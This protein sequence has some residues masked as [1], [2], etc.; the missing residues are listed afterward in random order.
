LARWDWGV[1]LREGKN[2]EVYF[3]LMSKRLKEIEREKN[4]IFPQVY[5]QFYDKCD[6][7]MP[8][9]LTGTDTINKNPGFDL[10]EAAEELFEGAGVENFLNENDFVF[11]MHQ[12]YQCWW[13]KADGSLDPIV[14]GYL[15]GKEKPDNMGPLSKFI[16]ELLKPS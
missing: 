3:K 10:N 11:M 5:S 13:F 7:K 2:Q 8:D 16:D 1:G 15:E 6:Y 9:S 14:Y 12:G 4:I